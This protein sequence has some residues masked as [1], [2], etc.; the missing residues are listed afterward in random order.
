M[1]YIALA[2]K[3]KEYIMEVVIKI[4]TDN[5]AFEDSSQELV[6]ILERI[7]TNGTLESGGK[8]LDSNGNTVGS[9]EYNE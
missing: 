8:I 9:V 5:A 7:A 2:I 6:D 3:N 1:M 4:N